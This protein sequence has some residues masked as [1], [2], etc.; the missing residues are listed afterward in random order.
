MSQMQLDDAAAVEKARDGDQD[1]FRVLVDRHSRSI[2]RLAFRMTGRVEDAEGPNAGTGGAEATGACGIP[3]PIPIPTSPRARLLR[4]S[5]DSTGNCAINDSLTCVVAGLPAA[6]KQ[7][8]LSIGRRCNPE[9]HS[10]AARHGIPARWRRRVLNA[11]SGAIVL[12]SA[13][14]SDRWCANTIPQ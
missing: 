14:S 9:G 12:R 13:R 2:Y 7:V 5:I 4:A 11:S 8:P 3:A 1:A 10:L 6:T